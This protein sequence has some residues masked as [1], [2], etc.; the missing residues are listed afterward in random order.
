[1]IGGV[2]LVVEGRD[3]VNDVIFISDDVPNIIF[4]EANFVFPWKN[5]LLA[6]P[7]ESHFILALTI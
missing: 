6:S 5:F 4:K 7:S 1:M 2:E 3:V